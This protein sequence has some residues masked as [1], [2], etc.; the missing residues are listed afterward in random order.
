MC[1]KP[2]LVTFNE[3]IL[4]G[5]LHFLCSVSFHQVATYF[6]RAPEDTIGHD[7]IIR[8]NSSFTFND[9]VFSLIILPR[10]FNRDG[11]SQQM[12]H[13]VYLCC[14]Y[15]FFRELNF[16]SKRSSENQ[17]YFLI[18]FCKLLVLS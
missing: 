1:R 13:L 17:R 18:Y 15:S 6:T 3:E 10:F 8:S 11:I 16:R 2:D 12:T 7:I 14:F 4:N 9:N 5:K